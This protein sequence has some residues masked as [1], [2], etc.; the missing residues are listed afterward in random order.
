MELRVVEPVSRI[1]P[2]FRSIYFAGSA[3][4]GPYK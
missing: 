2:Q 4:F 3:K 1:P